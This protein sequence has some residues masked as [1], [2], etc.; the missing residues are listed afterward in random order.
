LT[1][2]KSILSTYLVKGLQGLCRAQPPTPKIR[3][4]VTDEELFDLR[5][6]QMWYSHGVVLAS[7]LL[8]RARSRLGVSQS[9]LARV[10][11]V[12]RGLINRYE[13]GHVEPTVEQFNRL[14]APLDQELTIQRV[15]TREDQRSLDLAEQVAELLVVEPDDVLAQARDQL[16]RQMRNS[17]AAE[18]RWLQVWRAVLDLPVPIVVDLITDTSQFGRA[19]RQSSPLSPVVRQRLEQRASAPA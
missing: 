11:G 17:S 12:S 16:A 7:D 4:T 6:C 1:A 18:Q 14:L 15:L 19:L 8:V 3:R 9:R 13:R 5:L 2:S 10:S